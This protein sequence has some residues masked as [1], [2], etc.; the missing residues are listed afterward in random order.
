MYKITVKG[1]KVLREELT[2]TYPTTWVTI[3]ED[4]EDNE[5]EQ[6]QADSEVDKQ[7]RIALREME[8]LGLVRE[9]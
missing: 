3:L 6:V 2:M 5:V 9:T 4:L 1:K 8:E 7:T